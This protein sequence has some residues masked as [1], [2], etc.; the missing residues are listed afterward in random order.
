MQ[1]QNRYVCITLIH[2][3]VSGVDLFDVTMQLCSGIDETTSGACAQLVF[4][5][6]DESFGDDAPLLPSGF[7]VIPLEPKSVGCN[8]LPLSL[9][10]IENA[11][12]VL[13]LFYRMVLQ[14]P[15]RWTWLLPLR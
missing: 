15:G 10:I 8:S 11:L 9:I 1:N 14:Q 6:I 2:Y 12:I 13:S 3:V 7:R 5:P 4:A